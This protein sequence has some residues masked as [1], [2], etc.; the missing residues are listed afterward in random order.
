[1]TYTTCAPYSGK[2]TCSNG[3]IN[4]NYSFYKY[5]L[6]QCQAGKPKSCTLPWNAKLAHG[7]SVYGY[8]STG[9]KY[10][11]SCSAASTKLTCTNGNLNGNRQ[12]F[13]YQTCTVANQPVNG[14]D[15]SIAESPG[16]GGQTT[17]LSQGSNPILTLNIQNKGNQGVNTTAGAGFVTCTWV[18]KSTTVY[19]SPAITSLVINAMSKMPLIIQIQDSF[20]KTL[21]VHTLRCQLSMNKASKIIDKDSKNN[22]R[23]QAYEILTPERFDLAMEKSISSIKT[24]LDAASA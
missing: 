16:I 1:M 12:A 3:T 14:V 21:G 24:H 20:T 4:G 22:T 15:L 23:E 19:S 2:L 17:T 7:Q 18:E 9:V 6:S 5:S 11:Q 13:Q 8:S 10:P